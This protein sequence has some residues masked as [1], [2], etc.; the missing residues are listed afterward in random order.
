MD[1]ITIAHGSGGKMTHEL[2]K[3]V[4]LKHFDNEVL[5]NTEDSAVVDVSSKQIAFTTDSFVV[6]PIFFPGG[7][8]GKISVCGTVNDIAVSG[9]IVKYISCGFIIEAGFDISEL[10]KLVI[11]MAKTAKEAGVKIVAGDTKVV[12][13]KEADGIFINTSGIG[14]FDN[15]YRLGVKNIKPGDKI[16]ISGTLGDHGIAVLSKRKHL[17]FGTQIQSDCAPLNNM[18]LD[19]AKVSGEYLRFMR[20]PTRGGLATT[21]NE[22]V[23]PDTF[24]ITIDEQYIPVNE[25]VKGACELLGLDPLYIANEGKVIIIVDPSVEKKVLEQLKKHQYGKDAVTIGIVTQEDAGKVLLKTRYGVTRI[26]D[27]LTAEQLPRIC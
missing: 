27:M 24:G 23:S 8:I 11:S 22:I 17:E 20:D 21:L 19:V 13:N 7:D 6:K 3:N 12:D 16:I 4:F 18:L 1:K 2:I 14:V 9:A 26:L 10:E 15:E 25:A 5:N